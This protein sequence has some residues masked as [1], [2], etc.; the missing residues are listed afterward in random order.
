MCA[1]CRC[2]VCTSVIKNN[3][4]YLR[5]LFRANWCFP[6]SQYRYQWRRSFNWFPLNDKQFSIDAFFP[7]SNDGVRVSGLIDIT[8]FGLIWYH[9]IWVDLS[10][11]EL[12]WVD[13]S[14][15]ELSRYFI[16]TWILD[17]ESLRVFEL[18]RPM[19]TKA[20]IPPQGRWHFHLGFLV[21]TCGRWR[22]EQ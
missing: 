19:L 1:S 22:C 11:F 18:C 10:W 6:F 13:L 8:R 2:L 7:I 15:F 20:W 3:P 9:K 14:W 17:V 4:Q 5:V 16:F 12:I 21:A